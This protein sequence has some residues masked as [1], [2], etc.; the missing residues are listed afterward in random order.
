MCTYLCLHTF[1][2]PY[3]Q[4]NNSRKKKASQE[5]FQLASHSVNLTLFPIALSP[6]LTAYLEDQAVRA[7]A[8][9]LPL[10]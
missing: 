8:S 7:S 4:A 9:A 5:L 6:I 1:K 2:H 10:S 3:I